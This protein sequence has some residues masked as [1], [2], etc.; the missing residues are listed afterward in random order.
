MGLAGVRCVFR[1]S[2]LAPLGFLRW[3]NEAQARP[4]ARPETETQSRQPCLALAFPG[5]TTSL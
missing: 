3:T 4:P 2:S 5:T 1:D